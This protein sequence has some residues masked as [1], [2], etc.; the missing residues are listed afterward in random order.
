MA[1]IYLA[2]SEGFS[3]AYLHGYP[4]SLIV[5]LTDTAKESFC[6][7]WHR[8]KSQEPRYGMILEPSRRNIL[9]EKSIS[10][11]EDS[12]ARTSALQELARAWTASDLAFSL[13]S[14]DSFASYDPVSSSW[15]TFQLSILGGLTEFSWNSMRSGLMRGG[16]LFQPRSLA[17]V[18]FENDGSRFLPTPTAS[19]YG[20]NVGRKSDGTPSGR[21]RWSL[22]V[23]ARRGELPGH[24]KGSL[25]PEWIE[26]AMGY[27]CGWTAITDWVTQWYRPKREKRLCG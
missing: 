27:P 2:E 16:L 24:P 3:S 21:D 13:K 25:N 8:G 7:E 1:W 11:P 26:Q 23:R 9:G 15:R 12:P 14:S 20:K 22:T 6:R 5:R 19:D 17:A 18:T 10:L 4:Q